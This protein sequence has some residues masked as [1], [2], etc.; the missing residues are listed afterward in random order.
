[1]TNT[2]IIAGRLVR[3]PE[4]RQTTTDKAVASFTLANDM[5]RGENKKTAFIDCVAWER[6]AEFIKQ[7]FNKGDGMTVTGTLTTRTWEKDGQK[8]KAVEVVV[9][10]VDFPLARKQ[11]EPSKYDGPQVVE[12]EDEDEELPF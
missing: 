6:T 3:D 2:V 4:L 7:Y 11:E 10:E 1:M 8:H 12:Y 9:R 5:G